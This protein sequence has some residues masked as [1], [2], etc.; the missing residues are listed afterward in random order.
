MGIAFPLNNTS[1][2]ERHV[3]ASC[4]DDDMICVWDTKKFALKHTLKG[5]GG[6]IPGI[7]YLAFRP[8]MSQLVYAAAD[9]KLRIWDMNKE[10]PD[11]ILDVDQAFDQIAY[12]TDSPDFFTYNLEDLESRPKNLA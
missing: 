5:G 9:R 2:V 10:A 3:L 6:S 12:N 8:H 1:D 7:N 11:Y 4:G